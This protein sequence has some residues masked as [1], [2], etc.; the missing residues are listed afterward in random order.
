MKK[1]LLFVIAVLVLAAMLWLFAPVGRGYPLLSQRL[2]PLELQGLTGSL[3]QG[4]ARSMRIAGVDLGQFH[5]HKQ[6]PTI[7]PGLQGEYRLQGLGYVLGG[8]AK[9]SGQRGVQAR[10]VNGHVPWQ[11]IERF[12]RLPA[13]RLQAEPQLALDELIYGPAGMERVNGRVTLRNLRITTPFAVLLG[14]I[15]ADIQ[16][17]R[18]GL[19]IGTVRSDSQVLDVSGVIYLHPHRFEVN[20]VLKPKPGEYEAQHA[21]L[22]IGQPTTG[23]GRRIQVAGF[24]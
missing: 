19:A 23:G 6:W 2:Q 4:S 18:T 1:I 3:Y 13:D 15:W 21:L 11:W 20:L 8:T 22:F 12:L 9:L 16:T 14:D 10:S 24:Y 5:W 17:E 7:P